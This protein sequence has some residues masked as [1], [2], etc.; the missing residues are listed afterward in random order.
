MATFR[1]FKNAFKG[2]ATDEIWLNIDLIISVFENIETDPKTNEV[3]SSVV[4]YSK[5]GLNWQ[6]DE[7]INEVVRKLTGDPVQDGMNT[8]FK[9]RMSDAKKI[10]DLTKT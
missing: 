8:H 4:L 2:N 10:D 7:P 9:Q 1:K 5:E 3:K 6:V